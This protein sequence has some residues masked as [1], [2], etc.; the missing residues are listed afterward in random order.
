MLFCNINFNQKN[1]QSLFEIQDKTPKLIITV[2]AAFIVE[3]NNSK[4]FFD[5]LNNNYVTFDGTVPYLVAKILTKT[6]LLHKG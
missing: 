4:R 6:G 2:N 5:I 1:K 3:A